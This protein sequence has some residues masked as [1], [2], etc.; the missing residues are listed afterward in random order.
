LGSATISLDTDAGVM[1]KTAD[2]LPSGRRRGQGGPE[3][4]PKGPVI[5][6]ESPRL[7]TPRAL[8]LLCRWASQEASSAQ[9]RSEASVL[10]MRLTALWPE[11]GVTELDAHNA[12]E[13][14]DDE[15]FPET[16]P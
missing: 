8:V 11:L 4:G 14:V 7:T 16:G 3:T 2:M 5:P 15:E 1:G 12:A 9:V 6:R 13:E 10:Y